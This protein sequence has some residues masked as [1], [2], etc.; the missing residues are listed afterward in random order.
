MVP[1]A[2]AR[3]PTSHLINWKLLSLIISFICLFTNI[4]LGYIFGWRLNELKVEFN[5]AFLDKMTPCNSKKVTRIFNA[6]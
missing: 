6:T 5:A 4:I 3:L 2:L 1:N